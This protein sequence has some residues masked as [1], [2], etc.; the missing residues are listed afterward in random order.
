MSIFVERVSLSF[1]IVASAICTSAQCASSSTIYSDFNMSHVNQMMPESNSRDV[2]AQ[3]FQSVEGW[4][5]LDVRNF[6][7]ALADFD[8]AIDANREDVHALA[9]RA[10]A[11]SAKQDFSRALTDVNYALYLKPS[12][13]QSQWVRGKIY[14][15]LNKYKDAANLIN[16]EECANEHVEIIEAFTENDNRYAGKLLKLHTETVLVGVDAPPA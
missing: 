8:A 5:K 10:V 2:A 14:L 7:G 3:S 6:D 1:L 16:L 4:K 11:N 13:A 9:G 12:D 15:D